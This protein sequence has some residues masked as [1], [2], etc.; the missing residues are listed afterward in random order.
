MHDRKN[1][2]T[3]LSLGVMLMILA[4]LTPL[5]GIGRLI[6]EAGAAAAFRWRR[7]TPVSQRL[8]LVEIDDVSID[9]LGPWPWEKRTILKLFEAPLYI[10]EMTVAA[11]SPGDFRGNWQAGDAF[12]RGLGNL[13]S[14]SAACEYTM[15]GVRLDVLELLQQHPAGMQ[16]AALRE[17]ELPRQR[18]AALRGITRR[19]LRDDPEASQKD[20]LSHV[21]DPYW[22]DSIELAEMV[23]F[24]HAQV[25]G[26]ARLAVHEAPEGFSRGDFEQLARVDELYLPPASMLER[27]MGFAGLTSTERRE[28]HAAHQRPGS[29]P[30]LVMYD[31][32]TVERLAF[33]VAGAMRGLGGARMDKTRLT[34]PV[35]EGPDWS[36]TLDGRGFFLPNWTG[37]GQTPWQDGFSQ[38]LSAATVIEAANARSASWEAYSRVERKLGLDELIEL[39]ARYEDAVESAHPDAIIDA[40][41]AVLRSQRR[42]MRIL[43]E[44]RDEAAHMST[45]E[46]EEHRAILS[47]LEDEHVGLVK[48]IA[49]YLTQA[50]R[51]TIDKVVLIAPTAEEFKTM[52]NPWGEGVPPAA[53]EAAI[54][55]SI[56]TGKTIKPG[57]WVPTV[58]L[59]SAAALVTALAGRFG[60]LRTLPAVLAVTAAAA[61]GWFWLFDSRGVL[62]S[63]RLV[64]AIPAGYIAGVAVFQALI[65]APTRRIRR[66]LRGH[67]ERRR[68]SRRAGDIESVVF[69]RIDEAAVLAVEMVPVGATPPLSIRQRY[70]RKLFMMMRENGAVLLDSAGEVEGA[71]GWLDEDS[72]PAEMAIFTGLAATRRLRMLGA[73]LEAEGAGFFE[74]RMGIGCG[75]AELRRSMLGMPTIQSTGEA[76]ERARIALAGARRFKAAMAISSSDRTSLEDAYELGKL[77]PAGE[78][79]RVIERKGAATAAALEVRDLYESALRAAMRDETDHAGKLARQAMEISPDG[80]SEMLVYRIERGERIDGK[81]TPTEK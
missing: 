62:V 13:E 76:F 5:L 39:M 8:T 66:M 41:R 40:E 38:R 30:A 25:E 16:S 33:A 67:I 72:D 6:D 58:A 73:K 10:T 4:A 81:I 37:N 34:V 54:L 56:L 12:Y 15:P 49:V 77:D 53:V 55:N 35:E 60:A 48:G 22:G 52:H 36:V 28:R 69:R 64:A 14:A 1:L 74:L 17:R 19:L 46:I 75:S 21:L 3:I 63:L 31:G 29:V 57:G 68:V 65:A 32:L 7:P 24:W 61:Y 20:L 42:I 59:I 80:P 44:G 70:S 27:P 79:W 26:E 50:G 51:S 23:R 11:L 78:F 2:A 43:D 47:E 71:Y 9:A 45:E 18:A